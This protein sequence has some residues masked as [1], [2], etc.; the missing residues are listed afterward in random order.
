MAKGEISWRRQAEGGGKVQ[1]YAHRVG[2]RWMFYSRPK[3]YEPWQLVEDPPLEDWLALL[4][5]VERRAARRLKRPEEVIR[6]RKLIHERFPN[7]PL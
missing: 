4:D 5:G 7:A 2:D 6:I 3:R 1:V